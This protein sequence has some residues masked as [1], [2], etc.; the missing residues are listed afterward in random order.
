MGLIYVDGVVN[1]PSGVSRAA[2][3]LVDS[4]AKYSLLPFDVWRAIGL[5]SKRRL[6]FV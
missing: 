1:G 2:H 5:A 3:F 6:T 4:G